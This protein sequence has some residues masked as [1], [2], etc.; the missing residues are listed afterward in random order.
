MT[1][2]NP[3]DM[4]HRLETR[5]HGPRLPTVEERAQDS[6][7][8][9]FFGISNS[10]QSAQKYSEFRRHFANFTKDHAAWTPQ[11]AHADHGYSWNEVKLWDKV[12]YAV[13]D[14]DFPRFF[15]SFHHDERGA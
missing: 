15:E 12:F 9:K 13:G 3:G 2:D 10:P 14:K 4:D 11:L 8:D 1:T 7:V 6:R 5:P